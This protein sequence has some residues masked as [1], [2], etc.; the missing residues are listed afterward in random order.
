[1][2]RAKCLAKMHQI[3]KLTGVLFPSLA[4]ARKSP[5]SP[6]RAEGADSAIKQPS[7]K[8]SAGTCG[9]AISPATSAPTRA[10]SFPGCRAGAPRAGSSLLNPSLSSPGVWLRCVARPGWTMSRSKPRRFIR[11]PAIR[12]LFVPAGHSPGASL[13]HKAAEANSFTTL[14]VPVVALDDYFDAGERVALLK[15]DVEGA[16]LGVFQGA[17]RILRQH[18]PLLVFECENRHLAPGSVS[19]VFSYLESARLRGQL[20]LPQP[21][22]ADRRVRRRRASAPGRRMVLEAQGLLQQ[23]CLSQSAR[24][25]GR[26]RASRHSG[27]RIGRTRNPSHGGRFPRC[28]IAHLRSGRSHAP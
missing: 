8:S 28:A 16:E 3:G 27:S 7:S 9:R 22:P 12:S 23:F 6:S 26:L 15:I 17:E 14:S 10:V 24:R 4:D 18:A 1:M 2:L 20:H 25:A 21:G 19:D 13:T 11:I 5:V